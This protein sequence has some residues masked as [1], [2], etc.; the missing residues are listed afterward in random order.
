MQVEVWSDLVCPWCA[1]GDH[2][3]RRALERFEHG[4][5]VTV[6][7]RCFELHPGAARADADSTSAIA[8]AYRITTDQAAAAQRRL[9]E[10]ALSEGLELHLDAAKTGNTF[11]AHRLV[12]AAYDHGC[13]PAVFERLITAFLAEG[14]PV[15]DKQRLVTLAHEAGLRR[16]VAA[17]VCEGTRYAGAV[18]ADE[19]RAHSLGVTGV[20]FFL[21]AGKVP[22][23]GAQDTETMVLVLRR[24]WN[25]FVDGSG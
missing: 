10:L 24:A 9:E 25:R 19:D 21:V 14:E 23:P 18:R 11:D 20:P 16:E 13:G 5:A 7:R 17:E 22:M 6:I 15:D 8:R 12:L 1:I 3:L 2:R 4:E